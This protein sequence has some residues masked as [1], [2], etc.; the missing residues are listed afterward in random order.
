MPAD[1]DAVDARRV[2]AGDT[3]AFGGIVERWQGPLVNLAY[4]FCH[5]HGHAEDMAQEAFLK[6]YRSLASWRGEARFSTWLFAIALNLYRSRVRRVELPLVALDRVQ[7]VDEQRPEDAF[8]DR[9]RDETVRRA[10]LKL[11]A[12]YRDATILY[13]F[14]DMD[15]AEAAATLRVPTGTLKARLS[16]GRD[17]LRKRLDRDEVRARNSGDQ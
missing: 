1:D 9:E 11:P 12:K 10:V 6:A 13:Y 3:D 17:L 16:R 4:R 7:L 15:V 14:H 8:E 2:L 5:D